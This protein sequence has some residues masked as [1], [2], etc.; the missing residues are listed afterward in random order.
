[1]SDYVFPKEGVLWQREPSKFFQTFF[2]QYQSRLVDLAGSLWGFVELLLFD[3]AAPHVKN[4]VAVT[5]SFFCR[6]RPHIENVTRCWEPM[7]E[8]SKLGFVR[9]AEVFPSWQHH[10]DHISR[11]FKLP[12]SIT[13]PQGLPDVIADALLLD[14]L[15]LILIRNAAEAA[16]KFPSGRVSWEVVRRLGRNGLGFVDLLIRN[17]SET[18][19]ADVIQ[20]FFLPFASTKSDPKHFGLGLP[21]AVVLAKEMGMIL[22]L[23]YEHGVMTTCL[24]IPVARSGLSTNAD[25]EERYTLAH[26]GFIYPSGE[27]ADLGLNRQFYQILTKHYA[28]MLNR[29][30]IHLRQRVKELFRHFP[31]L[32][33]TPEIITILQELEMAFFALKRLNEETVQYFGTPEN[34]VRIEDLVDL[35]PREV[36]PYWKMKSEEICSAR[37]IPFDFKHSSKLPS[38]RS[39]A[40][41]LWNVYLSLLNNA[42]DSALRFPGSQVDVSITPPRK[43]EGGEFVN[44]F[45]RNRSEAYNRKA[46]EDLSCPFHTWRNSQ[47][48]HHSGLGLT[49]A[50]VLA[51]DL[52]LKIGFRSEDDTF[53][54]WMRIP[55]ASL[56]A[57]ETLICSADQS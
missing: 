51:A 27:D 23:R 5:N 40:V 24:T 47:D 41:S 20:C 48:S 50:S 54:T 31:K 16:A 52:G 49:W 46:L 1:M 22:G 15:F 6:I 25:P 33:F 10:S 37:K 13:Q 14:E 26:P 29:H 30:A 44:L 11:Q 8:P 53:T 55:T 12:V 21:E 35:N 36:F 28:L 57:R 32:A 19:R 38:I 9:W 2:C 39:D 7:K 34:E 4:D 17:T 45:I 18:F 3:I 42:V 43:Q 56:S